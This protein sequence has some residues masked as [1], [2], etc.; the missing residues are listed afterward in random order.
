MR[1]AGCAFR[2]SAALM[3]LP[4]GAA[5]QDTLGVTLTAGPGLMLSGAPTVV[6]TAAGGTAVSFAELVVVDASGTGSGWTVQAQA[7]RSSD[8]YGDL[9]VGDP[10]ALHAA[11]LDL[12]EGGGALVTLTA[13][14]AL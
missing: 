5:G 2:L 11:V 14:P 9:V 8:E 3:A 7:T 10:A 4:A 12:P 6:Q 1:T 13:A